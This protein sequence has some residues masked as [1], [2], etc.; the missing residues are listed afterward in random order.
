MSEM[1]EV[2]KA[3]I[4][5]AHQKYFTQSHQVAKSPKSFI[6]LCDLCIHCVFA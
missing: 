4:V 5:H 1:G 6:I 2:K 3:V